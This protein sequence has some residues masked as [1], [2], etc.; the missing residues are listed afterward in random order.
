MEDNI[1]DKLDEK[2]RSILSLRIK[3]ALSDD[4]EKF[5]KDFEKNYISIRLTEL[6]VDVDDLTE[7]AIDDIKM[8]I[9]T[10]IELAE[11]DNELEEFEYTNRKK[12]WHKMNID[13]YKIATFGRL[14]KSNI[15]CA[16]CK[17]NRRNSGVE[18]KTS[19][20]C[21]HRSN[22]REY[23]Y[24]NWEPVEEDLPDDLFEI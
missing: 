3:I 8:E 18:C 24:N 1:L 14:E 21:L 7:A 10:D 6:M 16:T 15:R 4:F 23:E 2:L 12:K 13:S 9:E 17:H 5:G 19:S 22:G 20:D 11:D